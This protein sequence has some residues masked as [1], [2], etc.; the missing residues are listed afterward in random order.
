MLK[1][2]GLSFLKSGTIKLNG[3]VD[4]YVKFVEEFQLKDINLWGKF[5]HVF[6]AHEDIKDDGWRGE[7]WGKM[8]RGACLVY[9]YSQDEELYSILKKTV[10]DLLSKQDELGRIS[11][12]DME[13]EF[14]GWDM[15]SRK[16][17]I[18]GLLHFVDICKSDI[19]KNNIIDALCKHL[20]YILDKVGDKE[21]QRKIELTSTSWGGVNSCTI[22]EPVLDLYNRTQIKKYLDF[23]EYII[24][25]GGSSLGDLVKSAFE[26]KIIPCEYPVQKAYEVMSFFEGLLAYYELTGDEYYL[27]AV[28]N[29]VEAVQKTEITVIGCAGMLGECFNNAV[30]KQT[31]IVEHPTQETCV[32][33]TWMRL[34][35]RL[36]KI[37]GR[38]E[39]ANRIELSGLNAFFGSINVN[40]CI[41]NSKSNNIMVDSIPFD[42]Y[43]PLNSSSRNQ[44]IGGFK[45]LQEG[46]HYGCCACIGSAGV[47]IIPLTTVMKSNDGYLINYYYELDVD[48]EDFAFSI[49]GD[50]LKDKQV[51][52][53]VRKSTCEEKEITFRVPSWCNGLE[54]KTKNQNII[55]ENQS[56]SK[57]IKKV[58]EKGEQVII[59]FEFDIT[60]SEMN[61]F[62]IFKYGPLVLA[63]DNQKEVAIT[64][65]G[66]VGFDLNMENLLIDR[67]PCKDGEMARFEVKDK[68]GD[69]SFILTD[70]ASCGKQWDNENQISVWLKK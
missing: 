8:M 50:Y 69:G 26:N 58:W 17:V 2:H 14:N 16:Y 66:K 19:L 1:R 63:R 43:S 42:S 11:S 33:V 10:I 45:D 47:A 4:D 28:N 24:K 39:Y 23:A 37:T 29:F 41:C 65:V 35:T 46:G 20:D 56:I 49:S 3:I 62:K 15:W 64:D 48:D 60:L 5:T 53:T 22:L 67:L 57:S 18:T 25:T 27:I 54:I 30:T 31:E 70:Y 44:G 34:L 21:G 52:L 55:C 61:G 32:T 7:Y 6:E 36:Y 9:Y 59:K 68:K 40:K 51:V 13:R 12:Y 38:V